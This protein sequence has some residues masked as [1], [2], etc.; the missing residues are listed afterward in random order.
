MNKKQKTFSVYLG[1]AVKRLALMLYDILIVN[2]SYFMALVIR[3]YVNGEFRAIAMNRYVPAFWRFAPYYTV[4]SVAVFLVFKM[5]NNRWKHAGLHDLNSIFLA[6]M[7][8]AGIHVV[9]TLAFVCRMPITY[10]FIGA[11]LQFLMIAV[12]RFSY[13][14]VMLEFSRLRHLNNAKLNVMIVGTGETAR[15]LRNQIERDRTNVAKPVCVFSYHDM[16]AGSMVNGLPV[17]KGIDKLAEH[18]NKY[19][20]KCVILADSIMPLE[21]RKQIR[22]ACRKSNVEVQDFSGY[23][24]N[25]SQQITLKNLMEYTGGPVEI[26]LEGETKT[27]P[28]GEEAL[29]AY[30]GKYEVKRLYA[31]AGKLGVEIADK[32]VILNDTNQDWVKET[33]DK[34]GAE[35]SF[36]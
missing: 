19:Q 17:L 18:I 4:I 10:Y 22:E 35:I 14:I 31:N 11:V 24:N 12:S 25:D 1:W 32:T 33:E 29:M 15:I 36:F 26:K 6:S 30:P 2:L 27:F 8:T 7:V 9:G 16:P 20:I 21:M 34:S 28:N 23:L 5:Y 3:F 13:R